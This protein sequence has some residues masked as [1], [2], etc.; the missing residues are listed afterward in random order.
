[1]GAVLECI[2]VVATNQLG[3]GTGQHWCRFKQR[4]FLQI[5]LVV[6]TR[7]QSSLPELRRYIR[8]RDVVTARGGGPAF[9]QIGSEK[10]NVA[11]DGFG[12][13]LVPGTALRGRQ[14]RGG[15]QQH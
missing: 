6:A 7:L 14:R 4:Y 15:H 11:A 9:Q 12:L 5:A 3:R 8:G 2:R 13:H 10:F 1:V